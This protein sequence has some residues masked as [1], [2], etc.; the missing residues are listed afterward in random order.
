MHVLSY[1]RLLTK[2]ALLLGRSALVLI[3]SIGI[4]ASI[5]R[6]RMLDHRIDKLRAVVEIS[7]GL[8]QSPENQVTAHQLTHEQASEQFGTAAHL[9]RFDAGGIH[10]R[11]DAGQSARSI[12]R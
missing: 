7:I 8:A 12:R 3:V 5:L 4:S 2:L 10:F 6:Q 11:A 9:M 1:P